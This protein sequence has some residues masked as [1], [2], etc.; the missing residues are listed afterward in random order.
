M[1]TRGHILKSQTFRP[2]ISVAANGPRKLND[3]HYSL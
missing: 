2:D 1:A 3:W